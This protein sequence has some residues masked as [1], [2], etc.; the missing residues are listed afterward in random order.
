MPMREGLSKTIQS[1]PLTGVRDA[2]F[3][4]EGGG[5]REAMTSGAFQNGDALALLL[6]GSGCGAIRLGEPRKQ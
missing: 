3:C 2:H 6:I 4:Q 5:V 1:E